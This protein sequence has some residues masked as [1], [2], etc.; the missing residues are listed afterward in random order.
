MTDFREQR[1]KEPYQN[2]GNELYPKIKDYN[3]Y[4]E[5]YRKKIYQKN[6]R[7]L[8]FVFKKKNLDHKAR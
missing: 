3:E 4:K 8:S 1:L 2:Y 6:R 7:K 5:L